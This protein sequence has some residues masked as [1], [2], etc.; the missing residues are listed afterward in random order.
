MPSK[1]VVLVL[2]ALAVQA[3]GD[4]SGSRRDDEE[5]DASLAA[6]AAPGVDGESAVDASSE[7]RL[8][9]AASQAT[10]TEAGPVT[11]TATLEGGGTAAVEFVEGATTLATDPDAPYS[12]DVTFSFLE[13]GSHTYVARAT[14]AGTVIESNS[15]TISVDVDPD[16][17]FVD[18]E[19]GSDTAD[20]SQATPFKTIEKARTAAAANQ[21]IYLFPGIYDGSNQTVRSVG[22]TRPTFVRGLAPGVRVVGIN[23]AYVFGFAQ[24]GGVRDV[25]F[26]GPSTGIT[27]A[28]GTFTMSGATFRGFSIAV[29]IRADTIASIEGSADMV[30]NPPPNCFA[31]VALI[32]DN[33]T[34]TWEGGGL[35]NYAGVGPAFFVRGTSTFTATNVTIE[36]HV[37][38]AVRVW[39][40]S[41]VTLTRSRIAN[42]GLPSGQ[43]AERAAIYA[44][45]DNTA[46]PL[47]TSI[48]LVE[49][50][51]TGSPGPAIGFVHYGG[52]PFAQTVTL[53]RSH[54]DANSGAGLVVVDPNV[55]PGASFTV[56][57]TDS[58][59]DGNGAG[60]SAPRGTFSLMG[61]SVSRNLGKAIE[62]TSATAVNSLSVR[63]TTFD[64]N[65]GDAIAFAG[66]ATS[67]LDL[68]TTADP[69]AVIFQAITA[70]AV[71]VRLGATHQS[72]A[73][74]NTWIANEQ[75]ADATGHYSAAR[76]LT[77]IDVGRNAAVAPGSSLVVSD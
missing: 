38:T 47:T 11:L 10:V 63:G 72:S 54:L 24:G 12:T 77:S 68:G 49:T 18:P 16:G 3:C 58:T 74:G 14:I 28:G 76:T 32:Q 25:A 21:T 2:V 39:D 59:L 65:S 42:A 7:P 53:T 45:P 9:L 17:V 30:T 52:I 4:D 61:G 19:T 62:L 26:E 56:T 29:D 13:N 64:A 35:S 75:G 34:V 37:G 57:A 73:V 55:S 43:L 1:C 36:N 6:D 69:G 67:V 50:T 66:G 8:V 44:G 15:V 40:D 22:F 51:I 20:G 23:P 60:I 5:P 46:R 31:C 71:A 48:E 70:P 27:V 41:H 33:A